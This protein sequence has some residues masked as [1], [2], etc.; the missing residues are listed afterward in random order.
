MDEVEA[1]CDNILILKKGKT[2]FYGTVKEAKKESGKEN[3][4]E[5]YLWFTDEEE[6]IYENI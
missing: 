2:V 5:A 1:L 4:E 6:T 3:F